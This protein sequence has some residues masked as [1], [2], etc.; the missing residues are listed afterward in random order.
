MLHFATDI[1]PKLKRLVSAWYYAYKL[2]NKFQT[3]QSEIP[4]G[5]PVA[6]HQNLSKYIPFLSICQLDGKVLS[7]Q[8]EV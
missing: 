2:Q 6:C 8:V 4:K 3:H 5:A 1:L 7:R